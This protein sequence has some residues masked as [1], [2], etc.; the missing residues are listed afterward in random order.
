MSRS[1]RTDPYPI[2]AARRALALPRISVSRPAPGFVHPLSP[3]DIRTF[4][5]PPT[6]YGLQSIHLARDPWPQAERLRLGQWQAPGRILLFQ[7]SQSAWVLSLTRA[8]Q[9]RLESAGAV[10]ERG[11]LHCR[12]QWTPRKLRDFFLR[13][14]LPHELAHHQLQKESRQP[15]RRLYRTCDQERFAAVCSR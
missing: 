15:H 9:A 8:E 13:D 5:T 10:V 7:Q 14:V 2:R 11:R 1:L 4:L 3:A 6:C 12:V